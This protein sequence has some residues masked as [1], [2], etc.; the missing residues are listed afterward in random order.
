MLTPW[1]PRLRTAGTPQITRNS[2]RLRRRPLFEAL[3]SRQLMTTFTVTNSSD[4][5]TGSLRQ[6]IINSNAATAATNTIAF[7]IGGGGVPTISILSPL[8]TITQPVVVDATTQPG[9]QTG[10]KV[11]LAATSAA[12]RSRASRS[13]R[14]TARS[15]GWPSTASSSRESS[16]TA[17]PAT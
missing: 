4:D 14:Q 13:R 11:V 15:K 9:T 1:F 16:S 8:P 6:A 2:R 3:E 12:R 17:D 10:P 7:N 5:G